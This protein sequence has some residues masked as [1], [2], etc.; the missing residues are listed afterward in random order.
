MTEFIGGRADRSVELGKELWLGL[1]FIMSLV[2]LQVRSIFV[3]L[4][5]AG[6]GH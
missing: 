2:S 6:E 4:L 1:E 5:G 3:R